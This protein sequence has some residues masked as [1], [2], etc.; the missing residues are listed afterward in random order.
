VLLNDHLAEVDAD[1]ELVRFCG[2]APAFRSA[3][4]RCIPTAQRTAS[5][6]PANSVRKPSPVFLTLRPR[7]HGDFGNFAVVGLR[8]RIFG[9]P[10]RA[11]AN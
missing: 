6:T 10:G 2:E 5:T 4:P 1:A 7:V 11:L 9:P 3:M 8:G